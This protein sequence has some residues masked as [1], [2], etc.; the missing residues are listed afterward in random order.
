M[1]GKIPETHSWVSIHAKKVKN[2][3]RISGRIVV[4]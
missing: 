1:K 2:R 4:E 3:G